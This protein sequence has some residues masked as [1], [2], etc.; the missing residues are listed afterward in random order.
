M[1]VE[2]FSLVQPFHVCL[3]IY[4][5]GLTFVFLSIE[6]KVWPELL[7]CFY[8]SVHKHRLNPDIYFSL[9]QR[10]QLVDALPK[11][12]HPRHLFFV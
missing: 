1:L 9:V 8:G 3:H 10:E 4:F 12:R 7:A 11:P 6:I 2:S 5:L